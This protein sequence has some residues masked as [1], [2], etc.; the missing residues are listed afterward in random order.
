MAQLPSLEAFGISPTLGFL[1]DQPPL[2]SFSD[3][4]F[5]KIDELI[6]SLP[7]LIS[8]RS[9]RRTIDSL[10]FLDP[11]TL[12]HEGEYRRAYVVF[13]FLAHAYVWAGSE[14]GPVETIPA[15]LAEP[16]LHVCDR[17]G[18]E[19]VLSYAGLCLWN[20]AP[21]TRDGRYIGNGGTR[22]DFFELHELSPL[23]SFTGSPGES[24]FH[25]VP[26][27]NEAEGGPL[28]SLL[29]DAIAAGQRNDARVVEEAL[30]KSAHIIERMKQHLP[31]LYSTLDAGMFY[32]VLRPFLAGGKG[33]EEKGLPRGFVFQKRDGTER[34]VRCI[35]GSA[36]QSS[37][38]Q[39]LD[40]AL[41]VVHGSSDDKGKT[42]SLYQVRERRW[43]EDET[44]RLRES[45]W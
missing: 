16:F 43:E 1:S 10:A 8:T 25:H 26:V 41:G 20:W 24:A 21:K 3:P 28:V 31:K 45:W 29:L 37:L 33:M 18:T 38:F 27:L 35:G 5:A 36:A 13:G 15:Q 23:A 17:L 14:E 19:P 11:S 44:T 34:E 6:S 12:S 30:I 4:Q 32:H 2:T 9:L 39:F 42:E 40:S 7:H 22:N